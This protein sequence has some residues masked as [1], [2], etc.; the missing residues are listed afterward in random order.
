MPWQCSICGE[1]TADTRERLANH[2]GRCHG[3]DPNFHIVCGLD[4]CTTS[5]KKYFSWRKHLTR[6]HAEQSSEPTEG[7]EDALN[8]DQNRHINRDELNTEDNA[9]SA[10]LY[11]LK[12]QE[13]CS[14]THSAVEKIIANTTEI[15]RQ[16][17]S[18][19]E[20]QVESCLRESDIDQQT[21]PRLKAIFGEDNVANN[22][23]HNLETTSQQLAY[24]KT[25][26]Q[27]KVRSL[28]KYII[29]L[30]RDVLLVF[31]NKSGLLGTGLD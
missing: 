11:I 28:V 13:Q 30:M 1:F 12:I 18:T 7:N 22:P 27:L 20:M 17:I 4:G 26:F 25:E 10:A 16:A 19:V 3:N 29:I 5:F 31:V 21:I 6:N 24:F 14:L 2:I 9:R 23:F 15:V 8:Q